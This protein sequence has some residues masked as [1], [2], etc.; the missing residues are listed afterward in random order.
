MFVRQIISVIVSSITGWVGGLLTT[1][2]V[3]FLVQA[4][5]IETA[6]ETAG[7][8]ALVLAVIPFTLSFLMALIGGLIF[9]RGQ[10]TAA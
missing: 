4:I 9:N 2:F 7:L 1:V 5:G 10:R 3:P 8:L 6:R